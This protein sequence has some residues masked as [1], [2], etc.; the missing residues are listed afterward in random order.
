VGL[1]WELVALVGQVARRRPP[2][3]DPTAAWLLLLFALAVGAVA[4]IYSAF[5]VWM[6]IHCLMREPDKMFWVWLLVVVPFPGAI[7]YGVLRV[8][9]EREF[10]APAWLRQFTRGKELSRLE[11]AAEQIGNAHQFVQWGDALRD[12][13]QWDRAAEAYSR[14]LAKDPQNL[15][16]LWGAAQVAVKQKRPA[17]V[18][19]CCE[20][21]LA[22]DPQYKF[23][24]VSLAYARALVDLREFAAAKTYLEQH[25]RRW[26]HPEAVYLLAV[27][28]LEDGNPAAARKHL[29]EMLRD[30][31]ASPTAIA[32]KFGSWKSLA[33][34]LLKR[35]PADAV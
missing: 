15:P 12:T 1:S 11:T 20:Q 8:F 13:A 10:V 4:L 3:A 16:A 14:A 33:R 26:R 27:R 25:C 35:L 5:W 19:R 32:R 21:I 17:E 22:R 18:K 6:L 34:K 9:P 7:V 2:A 24:D 30:I 29:Q 23:G 28:C 31:N